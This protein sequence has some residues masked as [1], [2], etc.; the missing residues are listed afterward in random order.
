MEITRRR[1][2]LETLAALLTAVGK[3]VFIN[4]LEIRTP[5]IVLTILGWGTYIFFRFRQRPQVLSYWGLTTTGFWKSFGQLLPVVLV[6]SGVFFAYGYYYDTQVVDWTLVLILL[7]Y[8]IWGILQHFLLLGIFGRNLQDGGLA[9][10]WVIA[11]TS[12]LFAVIHYPSPWLIGATFFLA[13]VYTWLYLRGH[14][15]LV[16]G[17][18]HGWLGGVFFYTV[19]GRNPWLEAFG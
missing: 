15:L 4:L 6:C 10:G 19:L 9:T 12:V 17:I 8:P 11:L 1:R 14:N 5:Y 3:I 13:I 7:L 16:L 18:Y 2:L